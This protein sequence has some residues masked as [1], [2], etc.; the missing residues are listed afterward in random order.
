MKEVYSC[1]AKFNTLKE[2]YEHINRECGTNFTVAEFEA[3]YEPDSLW[4]VED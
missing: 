4:L 3:A 1:G 2:L